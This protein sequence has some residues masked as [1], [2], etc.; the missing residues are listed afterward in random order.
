MDFDLVGDLIASGWMPE[1]TS[2]VKRPLSDQR[3]IEALTAQARAFIRHYPR[4]SSREQL[5]VAYSHYRC[6]YRIF[7]DELVENSNT[8]QE[9]L[10]RMEQAL[11]Q[12]IQSAP[13]NALLFHHCLE[14]L[15]ATRRYVNEND[16]QWLEGACRRQGRRWPAMFRSYRYAR[17]ALARVSAATTGMLAGFST[18]YIDPDIHE[19]LQPDRRVERPGLQAVMACPF[20]PDAWFQ[21]KLEMGVLMHNRQSAGTFEELEGKLRQVQGQDLRD[22]AV[23]DVDRG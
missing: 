16:R 3:L 22:A 7:V 4:K 5:R 9:L 20:N 18:A 8:P 11:G 1:G 15:V 21:L 23:T 6:A 19:A 10:D 12:A 14:L 2:L 13:Q 17:Q